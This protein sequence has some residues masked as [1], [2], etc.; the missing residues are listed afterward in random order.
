M[1]MQNYKREFLFPAFMKKDIFKYVSGLVIVL[2][3][4][5]IPHP[6]NVE[7]IMGTMMP[8]SKRWLFGGMVFT[9]L[10]MF[11]FDIF[12]GTLGVWSLFT[13]STYVL[14]AFLAGFYFKKRAGVKHYVIFAVLGTLFYDFV[15]GVL[16]SVVFW[17]MKFSAAFTG[18]IPF[19]LMHLA[20]N[21]VLAAVVSPILYRWVV[22]N[23]DMDYSHV[24]ARIKTLF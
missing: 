7:P 4:R 10:A 11:L 20:G 13:I 16:G 23:P 18:Q 5:F 14:L 22:S 3:L 9:F 8:F 19:T 17:G 24:V 2:F 21:V 12:T 1:P 6:P 15:T